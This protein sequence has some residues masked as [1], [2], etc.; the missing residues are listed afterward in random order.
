VFAPEL[1]A[2]RD[3]HP[4]VGEVRGVG[5]FWAVELVSDR[6]TRTPLAPYG[7]SS[8]AMND[9]VAACKR[10]GLLP[11]VNFNRVHL[12]PPLNTAA[13]EVKEA[14][15]ILDEALAESTR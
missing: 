13:A 5:A 14:I 1:D 15:G 3:R 4:W 6:E 11:M 8:P 10:R 12:V 7:G 2:L 9:V